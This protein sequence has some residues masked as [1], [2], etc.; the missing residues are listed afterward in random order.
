MITKFPEIFTARL[1]CPAC[2]SL[3]DKHED[4]FV[5]SRPECAVHFPIINNIPVLINEKNSVFTIDDFTARRELFYRN[6]SNTLRNLALGLLPGI[7]MN[8]TAR[9]NFRLVADLLLKKTQAPQVLVV[10][11]R[12]LGQGM[13]RIAKDPSFML[14]ETDVA[15][16]GRTMLICDSH[17]IPFAD[18]TF[19]GVIVQ[20]VLEHVVDPVRCVEEIHRVLKKGGIVYAEAPFMQQVHGGRYDF[21]RYTHLGLRR[22]F[23]KFDEI[24][25][26]AICGPGMALAWS[27]QYFL[28]SFFSSPFMRACAK[29]FA[30]FSSFY[31][32]FFDYFLIDKP[33]TIDAASGFFFTGRKGDA[34]LSDRELLTLYRGSIS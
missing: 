8:V 2:R 20:A 33:G 9:K 25:S 5:C 6:G 15:F 26:G 13:E 14:V 4:D 34:V 19:D 18:A 11:G 12:V 29:V 16:G 1:R 28:K 32:K 22:L 23:R 17:D 21:T 31:L 27:Y 10:G 30:S 7:D 24:D 3:L